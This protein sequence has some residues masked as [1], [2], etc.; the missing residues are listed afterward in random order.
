VDRPVFWHYPNTYDQPPFSSVRKG[1]WKLIYFHGDRKLE[2]Y[3][4]STD[5]SEEEDL[6]RKRPETVRKLAHVLSVHLRQT[7][8]LMCTDI[9]SGRPVPYPDEVV[10]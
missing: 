6:S 3:N 5:I 9:A 10:H 2:L 1:D 8:S 7:G 4:V